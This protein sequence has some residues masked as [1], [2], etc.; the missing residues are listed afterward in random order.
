MTIEPKRSAGSKRTEYY[1]AVQER[2]HKEILKS[3]RRAQGKR[4]TGKPLNELRGQQGV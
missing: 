3:Y 4:R 2:K 1:E